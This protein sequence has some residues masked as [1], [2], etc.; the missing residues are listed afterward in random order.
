MDKW[1]DRW[2]NKWMDC[3]IDGGRAGVECT[4]T[5]VNINFF[6]R[7]SKTNSEIYLSK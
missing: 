7:T 1:M 4:E 2:M 3:G 6:V 5:T